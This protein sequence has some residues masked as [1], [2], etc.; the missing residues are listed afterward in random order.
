MTYLVD[1][2][3][4][5]Y[6]TLGPP[7]QDLTNALRVV[8]S[9]VP[10][11][12]GH[13]KCVVHGYDFEFDRLQKWYPR[14]IVERVT[15]L[16]QCDEASGD[17]YLALP[18]G[19]V[20]RIFAPIGINGDEAADLLNAEVLDALRERLNALEV[21]SRD[22]RF[23]GRVACGLSRDRVCGDVDIVLD[24]LHYRKAV[25]R[26]ARG[27][28]KISLHDVDSFFLESPYRL[29]AVKRRWSLSQLELDACGT[30]MPLDVKV[31]DPQPPESTTRL[32]YCRDSWGTLRPANGIELTVTDAGGA[33]SPAPLIHGVTTDGKS[34]SVSSKHYMFSGLATEG[35]TIRVTGVMDESG[36]RVALTDPIRHFVVP[37]FQAGYLFVE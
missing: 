13:R 19:E 11:V 6:W 37:D 36:T 20:D 1:V 22:V 26:D 9:Y 15:A 28:E 24:G 8:L 34:L 30:S 2:A 31:V 7:L 17:Q 16:R 3:G 35:D 25:E 33:L 32:Y 27:R 12:G 5:I 23:Y 29:E 4:L 21:D 10:S 14:R 18:L